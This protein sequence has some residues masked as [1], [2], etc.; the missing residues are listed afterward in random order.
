[1][2][3]I[4][5]SSPAKINLTLDVASKVVGEPFHKIE[6]IYHQVSLADQMRLKPAERF[7]IEGD[8]DC[9][10][11][12]NFIFK[13]FELL[14]AEYGNDLPL[15]GVEV[16]KNIP[17]QGG[18]GGG[19][20]NFSSF[21]I[22]YLELFDLGPLKPA[23]IKEAGILGKDMPFFLSGKTCALG[24]GF[25]E[26]IQDVPF[27]EPIF[28]GET[29]YIYQPNFKHETAQSYQELRT[30]D[31]HFTKVFMEHPSLDN[32]GNTFDSLLKTQRYKDWLGACA[33]DVI[34]S[35]SGSCVVSCKELEIEST[36]H[37][38]VAL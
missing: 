37:W 6:T 28:E 15:V 5:I 7:G 29:L 27:D 38:E 2:R 20:S 16:E 11:E 14:R 23:F 8:F 36:K 18:L 30:W 1:M 10:M 31:T 35:G 34:L 3:S 25:G 19:S 26:V 13:A 21:V 32:M 9:E 22:A 17:M 12:Q 33:A 24:T 4:E